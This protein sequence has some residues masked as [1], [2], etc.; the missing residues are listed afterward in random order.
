MKVRTAGIQQGG[1][2]TDGFRVGEAGEVWVID[3]LRTWGEVVNG[4]RIGDGFEKLMLFGGMEAKPPAPGEVECD[5][6]NLVAIQTAMLQKGSD[7]AEGPN[8]RI[9]RPGPSVWQVDF[10]HL[11]WSIPGGAEM[12]FGVAAVRRSATGDAAAWWPYTVRTA[13]AHQIKLSDAHG[14]SLGVLPLAGDPAQGFAVQVWGHLPAAVVI[15]PRG[16]FWDVTLNS[17]AALNAGNT[18][19]A[20]LRF[21]PNGARPVT[22][23][24]QGDDLVMSFRAA[25]AG[26]RGGELNACLIGKRQDG[27]PFEGCDLLKKAR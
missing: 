20:S 27:V 19:R 8:V 4:A 24:S 22:T 2:P 15:R 10:D 6:H 26:I 21:G 17:G 1:F 13:T 3:R 14:K 7:S 12:Q 9:S 5:C 16:E 18:E 11:N 25:D 23:Q